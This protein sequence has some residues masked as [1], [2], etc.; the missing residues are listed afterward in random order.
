MKVP[1]YSYQEGN[2]MINIV[3]IRDIYYVFKIALFPL[4][5]KRIT[6]TETDNILMYN[7]LLRNVLKIFQLAKEHVS[8]N[9]TLKANQ[10]FG[11]TGYFEKMWITLAEKINAT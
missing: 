4:K 9:T 7:A 10:S 2:C 3:A 1:D 6:G 11:D 5:L 8:H